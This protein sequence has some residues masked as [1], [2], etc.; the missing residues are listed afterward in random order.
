L[1]EHPPDR[2]V[3]ISRDLREYGVQRYGEATGS[4]RELLQWAAANYDLAFSVGGDPLDIRQRGSVVLK[5]KAG[6]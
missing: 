3:V 5:R 6:P 1:E 4:G 2:V